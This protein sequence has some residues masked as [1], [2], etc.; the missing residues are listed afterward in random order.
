M[1]LHISR[2]PGI[3]GVFFLCF[4]FF[5]LATSL[6][7]CAVFHP[8]T[9]ATSCTYAGKMSI[10]VC[11]LMETR[12]LYVCA[13]SKAEDR[14]EQ[15]ALHGQGLIFPAAQ[16][17]ESLPLFPLSISLNASLIVFDFFQ[18]ISF[19]LPLLI[20]KPP[21]LSQRSS[22]PLSHG[23]VFLALSHSLPLNAH[24]IDVF[25]SIMAPVMRSLL[26]AFP[27]V[28]HLLFV[29]GSLQCFLP[30]Y[31]LSHAHRCIDKPGV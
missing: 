21:S 4:L 1:L 11:T 7:H 19:R 22:L 13:K 25:P 30:R 15:N 29:K 12:S 2:V 3:C 9:V 16:V 10:T 14:L 27:F 17:I 6:F 20:F 31:R 5:F 23:S 24:G 8:I 18:I 26:L 28:S